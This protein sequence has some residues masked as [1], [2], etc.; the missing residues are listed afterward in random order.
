[1]FRR[2]TDISSHFPFGDNW[3]S[4]SSTIDSSSI[5]NATD[6]LHELIGGSLSGR[7]F[8]DLG[9]GS[10]IHSL[11][12]LRLDASFVYALDLDPVSVETSNHTLSSYSNIE[13]SRW[14]VHEGSVLD[15]NSLPVEKFDIVYS[16]G[17]LHHTGDLYQAISNAASCV[18]PGGL[19][20]LS[21]YRKTFF[22]PFWLFEKYIYNH[23]PVF[24][25]LLFRKIYTF[26][27][28]LAL[29]LSGRDFRTFI[30]SYN[31]ARGMN[32]HYDLHD[33]LGGWPYQSISSHEL[34]SY[35]GKLNFCSS[36]NHYKST[37]TLIQKIGLF[38]SG[39]DEYVYLSN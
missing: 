14:E 3:K 27:F 16:W 18:K 1:M 22:D 26:F 10:G 13:F 15:I 25:Q 9:S 37:P 29:S 28:V 36:P 35:L 23:S 38:G 17:V 34:D 8:L 19:L 12:A 30:S 4:Y 24:I 6:S 11:A 7:T 39:C 21:L 32:Y 31:S 5:N 2:Q 20:V 33:W